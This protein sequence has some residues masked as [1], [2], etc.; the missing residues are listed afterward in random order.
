M[1]SRRNDRDVGSTIGRKFL[2]YAVVIVL[3][4][5]ASRNPHQAESVLHAIGSAIASWTAHAAHARQ[6]RS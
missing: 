5:W 1:A 2:A 4:I 3:I 6:Q